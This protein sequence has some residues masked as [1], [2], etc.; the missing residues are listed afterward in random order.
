L[1][2]LIVQLPSRDPAIAAEEWSLPEL[3][4]ALLDR[5]HK[6]L[7]TGRAHVAMLPR[8]D[9]TVLLVAARDVLMLQLAL[10]P[11]KG[12]RL[13]Q[14]LPNVVEDLLIQDVQTCHLALDGP[15]AAD[16]RRIVAVI[17]RNWFRFV[18]NAFSATGHL[19]LKAVPITRCLPLPPPPDLGA[20]VADLL[21][22]AGVI[23][24]GI[25]LDQAATAA[26]LKVAILGAVM[27]TA[28][29]I[30]TGVAL[31]GPL[32]VELAI[33]R[34]VR[35]ELGEGMALRTD[36]LGATLAA[37]AGGAPLEL[38]QLK[39][40]PGIELEAAEISE[41]LVAADLHA[42]ALPFES[43]AQAAIACDFD[44]CQFEFALQPW[45]LSRTTL[46]RWRVPAWLAAATL[47]VAL[48]AGNLDWLML[49]RQH[50]AMLE[51]QVELLM[52]TFP[53]TSVV[54]DP[55]VQMSRE[56]D[57]L[58]TQAGELAPDDFLSL[59][60]TLARSLAPLPPSAIA[61]IVY[62][63]R[64]LQVTFTATAEIDDNFAVRLRRNGLS[65]RQD[66][67]VWTI[68]SHL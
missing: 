38:Y 25:G 33:A 55:P 6:A 42:Q 10:P 16:G 3:P 45:R 20:A 49:S 11:V 68:G 63:E 46:R 13:L 12:P 15:V 18:I 36:T 39:G 9:A 59:S 28:P 24:P 67:A 41:A 2:T 19:R 1:S 23:E 37:L 26:P 56:L 53:K 58:R 57:H 32:H 62:K 47:A 5:Q 43:L 14:A 17:D 65:S 51:Q 7:R 40:V 66:G 52:T 21:V 64:S 29:A 60:N 30:W 61:Q 27:P 54:L 22:T 50:S 8:A 4:F 35:G 34:G 31:T 44:L 48:V